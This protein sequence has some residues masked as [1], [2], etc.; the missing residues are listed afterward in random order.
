MEKKGFAKLNHFYLFVGM[1]VVI[2]AMT[3]F[4][5]ATTVNL[6]CTSPFNCQ[7]KD[8][9]QGV[10]GAVPGLIVYNG[11]CGSGTSRPCT[12]NFSSTTTGEHSCSVTVKVTAM[13]SQNQSN[14]VTTIYING[15]NVGTTVDRYCNGGPSE[16]CTFC[17]TDT[18]TLSAKT[19]T[20]SQSNSI[21]LVGKDSHAIVAVI[22]NCAKQY[23]PCE[24]NLP[25]TINTISNKI[26]PYGSSFQ[27]NLWDYVKDPNGYLADVNLYVAQIGNSVSCALDGHYLNC[28]SGNTLGDTT[29]SITAKD[30]CDSNTTKSFKATV[31][32]LPPTL[33]IPDQK[34]SC[35]N[36]FNKIVNLRS[37]SWDEQVNDLNY[38]MIAQSNSNFL[39][40]SIDSNYYV[41]CTLNYCAEDYSDITI[42]T[43][44]IFGEHY[45]DVF[46]ISLAN[47][48]PKWIQNP[49]SSCINVPKNKF[50]DFLNY[51]NDFED[52]NNLSFSLVSQSNTTDI[53]CVIEENRYLS[54][55]SLSN[56]QVTNNIVVR[57]HDTNN[58]FADASFFIKTNCLDKNIIIESDTK[59]ICL[60]KCTSYTTQIKVSN[61]SGSRKCF[62][63]YEEHYPYAFNVSL[64]N[65]SFC[66]SDRESTFF[67]LS[68]NTCSSD[69]SNYT[70]SVID[71]DNNVNLS[72]DYEIGTCN[73]FD[74]F[75]ITE[76]D[77]K[78]CQGEEKNLAVKVRNTSDADKTI[79]LMAENSFV[80]PYFDRDKIFLNAN[81]EKEIRV[82]INARNLALGKYKIFLGGDAPNYHIE[83]LLNVE[84][85]DCSGLRR[86]FIIFSN[87]ICYDVSRGQLFEGS[88]TVKRLKGDSGCCECKD[89]D[90]GLS[91]S[92]SGLSY[93]LSTE[94]LWMTCL[95]EK[96]VDFMVK[97]PQDA[98]AG[99]M[100]F[101]I[102]GRE[103]SDGLFDDVFE[104]IESAQVCLKVAGVSNA[105]ISLRTQ[106]KD[107]EWCDSELFE[108]EIINSGDFDE[109]FSLSTIYYP[110]GVSVSFSENQVFV[111]KGSSKIIYVS[112]STNPN[113]RIAD[114][115]YIT[116]KLSGNIEITSKIYFNIKEKPSFTDLEILSATKEI[117]MQANTQATYSLILRNNLE[118]D[119]TNVKVYFEDVPTGV[120]FEEIIVP[121]LKQ[122]ETVQLSGKVVASDLNGYFEPVMIVSSENVINKKKLFL[123]VEKD[124]FST[125]YGG[126]F[127]LFS[128]NDAIYSGILALFL[129]ILVLI[130]VLGLASVGSSSENE[131][132]MEVDYDE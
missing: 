46:R 128:F 90:K 9:C 114:N 29:I 95:E 51:A 74:G 98:A 54:C 58:G 8:Y 94:S 2:L 41:S 24:N 101:N 64:E 91:L 73:S 71:E 129:I 12:Y 112:I 102:N 13:H 36:D 66:V 55:G 65:E 89:D 18:Q 75:R 50:I 109:N 82:N 132:W 92:L 11:T 37:Y 127:G 96:K 23:D 124:E 25:P 21:K 40:C 111:P 99:I 80:L 118:R 84:V 78:I 100:F 105:G 62:N 38:V 3:V 113:S 83:K 107:I 7:I 87:D 32:N 33:H 121:L 35:K 22:V 47:T 130:L 122:G 6:N 43:T 59:G 4:A 10:S 117:T 131:A 85:V 68:A 76:F 39:T 61:F 56:K 69:S 60:E 93:Q 86:N 115:Q 119:L 104:P 116:I 123:V 110:V 30:K 106:A 63:F 81:E 31:T 15:T 49:P 20:L 70:V 26:V 108:L 48:N 19:V 125:N 44:D 72:F 97:V 34:K 16:N 67:T 17:G 28:T 79:Y 57:V 1:L 5:N 45:D 103:L 14:E 27:V 88:F 77:G 126:M 52:G 53:K 120:N 42:R